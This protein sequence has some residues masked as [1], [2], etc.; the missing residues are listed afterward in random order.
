MRTRVIAAAIL[1]AS[2]T[3]GA[4]VGRESGEV[5]AVGAPRGERT[6][7]PAR[8]LPAGWSGAQDRATGVVAEM[9]GSYVSA[10]GAVADAN[11]AERAA[12]AFVAANL[13]LLA[14]GTKIDDLVL[15]ANREE[16]GLRTVWFQQTWRGAPVIGGLL[17]VMIKN[18]RVF[19]AS[20]QVLPNLAIAVPAR[21]GAVTTRRAEDWI[22][23][24]AV[25][26]AIGPRVVL[27]IVG[28]AGLE[29]RI[30]DQ[31][32]IET[33][34]RAGRWDVFVGVDGAPLL[35]RSR[36]YFATSTLQYD[37]GLRYPI[38]TR[39]AAA[40]PL[41]NITAAGSPTTTGA[42]GS[43]AWAG[44]AST[45]VVPGLVGPQIA[46][47][48]SAGPLATA[49]L[50]AQPGVPVVWS[51]ATDEYADAQLTSFINVALSKARARVMMP[52]LGSWLD[53]SFGVFV[54]EDD[55]CNAFATN[56]DIHFFRKSAM[57]ENT[58]RLA[59]VIDHE[60]GHSVHFH[61]NQI[62]N[63][64][65]SLAEGVA[66]FFASTVVED[67]G[68]GRG[69][70]FTD[71]AVRDIDPTSG[72][73]VWPRDK[74]SDPHITGLIIAG[75]LWDLRK[76]LIAQLGQTAAIPVIDTAFGG[77]LQNS[78]DIPGSYLAARTADDDDGN[79]GNG[80][81][82]GCAIEAAFGRHGLAGAGFQTTEVGTPVVTGTSFSVP[83]TMPT[84]NLCP[85]PQVTS[86]ELSWHVGPGA[87]STVAFTQSGTSWVGALP[88]QPDNTVV[89]Y[90]ITAKL[91]DGSVVAYPQNP[92]DLEY[93]LFVGTPT[94][95][96]CERFDAD[97]HWTPAVNADWQWGAPKVNAIGDPT[98][99]YA[100]GAVLGNDVVGDGRYAANA[101]STITATMIDVPG[102][103][104]VHLQLRRW[105][106]VEDATFDKATIA[107]NGTT[108]W[109]NAMAASEDLDH[110]DREWRFQ[111]VDLTSY[112]GGPVQLSWSL[113][114][115]MSRELGG[116][117][118]DEVCLVGVGKHA[119][120]GDGAIDPDEQCDDGN[121]TAG[122]GCST[123]CMDE[124]DPGCCSTGTT[125]SGPLL[126]GLG[127]V[128]A[129][130]RR[131]RR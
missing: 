91:D 67:H 69:F 53:G 81:P 41:A 106:T 3:A 85:P 60:F 110:I 30:A 61:A 36:L 84:G 11:V 39:H 40:V 103:D 77:V 120:C 128:I 93:T 125:P 38:G 49:S 44:A 101:T 6:L 97:P 80:T 115:D 55:T 71:A 112:A 111:D 87:P 26:R 1:L 25:T 98:T 94:E 54:N 14:P 31:L 82:H 130:A 102:F 121:A 99:A 63:F 32:D 47:S 4:W 20:S 28:S 86:V 57:C 79:L 113:A 18:D 45:T 100:G 89:R 107:V 126:L 46:I 37:V 9:W 59:D 42:D 24:R 108:V 17:A 90:S 124:D 127:V 119:A 104:Q 72:E 15:R 123:D 122:D 22:G 129:I 23:G 76:A 88:T 51:M 131:R 29:Y 75:A 105:L 56:D 74:V 78:L 5:A 58:G 13:A 52:S 34:D 8:A 66:D 48:S 50:T 19:A 83:V 96:W 116:W 70:D 68:L 117:N 64:S 109:T 35:R 92:A 21:T 73:A 33:T 12:R 118:I 7:V 43:F 114:S 2:G 10:P 65:S 27:P 16:R 95:I 62:G